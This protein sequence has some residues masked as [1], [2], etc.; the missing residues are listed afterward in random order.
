MSDSPLPEP[1]PRYTIAAFVIVVAAI[2]GGAILLLSTRHEAVQITINPP[3]ST[4]TPT[5]PA[6]I[7]VYVTGAVNQ[8]EQMLTL[9]YGSRT[10][11]ALNAA[12]GITDEADMQRVN[13]AAVLHDGDQVHVPAKGE[14]VVLA[15]ASGGVIV[16]INTA[17]ADEIDTLPG[18]GPSLAE[19]IITYREA[20]GPF[21]NFDD[22]DQ[23][24]G[25]GPSLLEQLQGLIAFD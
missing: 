8:P 9:P 3:P 24:E 21:R 6:P 23:V 25:I 13:L 12:G 17:T 11:D 18:I 19:Q 10:V 7:T 16:H 14:N 2:L 4:A 15:T 20:N 22:L 1:S 5:T